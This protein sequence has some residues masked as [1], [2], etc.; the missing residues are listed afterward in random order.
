[1]LECDFEEKPRK[2]LNEKKKT[3]QLLNKTNFSIMKNSLVFCLAS[4][5]T[6][7]MAIRIVMIFQN[8]KKRKLTK[9]IQEIRIN[10]SLRNS[11]SRIRMMFELEFID[12]KYFLKKSLFDLGIG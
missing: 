6:Y 4:C 2:H 7:L 11:D 3:K 12:N 10:A 5:V 1:M 9:A 8:K